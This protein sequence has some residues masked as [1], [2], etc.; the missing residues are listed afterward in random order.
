[1]ELK[2]FIKMKETAP[3]EYNFEFECGDEDYRKLKPLMRYFIYKSKPEVPAKDLEKTGEFIKNNFGYCPVYDPDGWNGLAYY[4]IVIEIYKHLWGW[5]RSANSKQR[6]DSF[7]EV[8]GNIFGSCRFGSDTM[9]SVQTALQLVAKVR[10]FYQTINKCYDPEKNDVNIDEKEKIVQYIDWYH[11][12]GNFVLVPAG[13]NG[14]R[15]KR[16]KIKD[17]WDLSLKYLKENGW[18]SKPGVFD[19]C[20]FNEY[21]NYFFLWDSVKYDKDNGCYNVR[22]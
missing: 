18:D 6:K 2:D 14:Y 12:L 16:K 20:K 4:P 7:A 15:G 13:F 21:I 19:K 11:T 8:E 5:K 3:W 9:N 10:S 1:M 17:F 22:D